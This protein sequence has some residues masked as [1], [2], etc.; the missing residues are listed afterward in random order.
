MKKILAL[1]LAT[2]LCLSLFAGCSKQ[3]AEPADKTRIITDSK[4]R[5]VEI[6]EEVKSIVCV[7]VGALRY[8]CYMGAQDLVVAV[9]D[10][11]KEA[12]ISRLYNYV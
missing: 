2:V 8:T 11:E 5:E 4:G 12:V 10:C 3:A 7:G 9:E 1:L 6:P